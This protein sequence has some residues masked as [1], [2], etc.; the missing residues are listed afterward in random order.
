MIKEKKYSNDLGCC[1]CRASVFDK[2]RNVIW[3]VT[4]DSGYLL[5]LDLNR[6][7]ISEG[8]KIPCMGNSTGYDYIYVT[9]EGDN[10]LINSYD[11]T[12]FLSIDVKTKDIKKIDL[13]SNIKNN[14]CSLCGNFKYNNKIYFVGAYNRSILCLN[15]MTGIVETIFKDDAGNEGIF[16][17]SF[18]VKDDYLY[19]PRAGKMSLLIYDLKLN[20]YKEIIINANKETGFNTIYLYDNEAFIT[21]QTGEIVNYNLVTESISYIKVCDEPIF[22]LFIIDNVIKCFSLNNPIIWMVEK[23]KKLKKINVPYK[24]DDTFGKVYSKFEFL[25]QSNDSIYFQARTSGDIWVLD[26][27]N[28]E[29]K[30]IDIKID[31]TIKEKIIISKIKNNTICQESMRI[32][33]RDYLKSF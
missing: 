12:I 5:K 33:I 17:Y 21:T 10:V 15:L 26:K 19:I 8:Y 13:N 4:V 7:T 11:G 1:V 25:C 23:N 32:N 16:T 2:K 24:Y 28:D 20:T 3:L 14:S 29:V 9:M 6:Y 30:A 31:E 27:E 18:A 22:G